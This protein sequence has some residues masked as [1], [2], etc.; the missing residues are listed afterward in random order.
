[1]TASR[2]ARGAIGQGD[3]DI[4]TGRTGRTGETKGERRAA[5]RDVERNAGRNAGRD[6]S[7]LPEMTDE[8]MARNDDE[9][10]KQ[11]SGARRGR[12]DGTR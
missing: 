7:R 11:Q 6:A 4:I 1:M 12:D 8:M 5:K 3:D 10:S 9:P 2:T